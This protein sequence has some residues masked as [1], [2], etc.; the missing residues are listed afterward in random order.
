MTYTPI[1][2]KTFL[3]VTLPRI[4]PRPKSPYEAALHSCDLAYAFEEC[5]ITR[6]EQYHIDLLTIRSEN[7]QS[8]EYRIHWP[9]RTTYTVNGEILRQD[10]PDIHRQLVCLKTADA[11]KI[12][13]TQLPLQHSTEICRRPHHP[14][15]KSHHTRPQTTPPPTELPHYLTAKEHTLDPVILTAAEAP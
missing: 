14:L 8:Q 15:R 13:R 2:P 7:C 9:T 4:H 6:L 11:E 1:D 12:P 5:R 10:H 3:T